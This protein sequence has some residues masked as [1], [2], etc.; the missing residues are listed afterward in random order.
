MWQTQTIKHLD[1]QE[2]L[3]EYLHGIG[4]YK[5]EIVNVIQKLNKIFR[6]KKIP[7]TEIKKLIGLRAD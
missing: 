7:I 2:Q 5:N 3:E 1:T 4:I 6:T